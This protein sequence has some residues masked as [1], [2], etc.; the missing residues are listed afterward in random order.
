[1]NEV[2]QFRAEIDTDQEGEYADTVFYV[3]TKLYFL[4]FKFDNGCTLKYIQKVMHSEKDK[5]KLVSS[6]KFKLNG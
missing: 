3:E 5:V 1:M 6:Q 4:R 2:C